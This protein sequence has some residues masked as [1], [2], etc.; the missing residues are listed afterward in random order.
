[1]VGQQRA[2]AR[3][4]GARAEMERGIRRVPAERRRAQEQMA[5]R[6]EDQAPAPARV[7]ECSG[8]AEAD[9]LIFSSW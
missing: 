9:V 5:R 1:M 8:A 3:Q 2:A 4:M 6:A 7:A